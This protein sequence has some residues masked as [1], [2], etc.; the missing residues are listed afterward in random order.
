MLKITNKGLG[1][2]EAEVSLFM[3]ASHLSGPNFNARVGLK[4]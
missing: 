2:V 4:A 3:A 1:G